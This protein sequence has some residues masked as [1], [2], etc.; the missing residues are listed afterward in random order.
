MWESMATITKQGS[1]WKAQIRRKGLGTATRSFIKKADAEAWARTTEA[2]IERGEFESTPKAKA[3]AKDTTL[4]QLIERYR[5]EISTK[6][7]G[8]RSE[9]YILNAILKYHICNKKVID[10]NSSDWSKYRDVR[11]KEIKETK[12][13]KKKTIKPITLKRQLLIFQHMYEVANNEWG[14]TKLDNP[15]LKVNL[16]Y[17]DT[18]RDRVLKGDEWQRII[19]DAKGRKN[20]LVLQ[21]ILW[22]KETGMRRGE[23][24]SLRW[25]DVDVKGRALVI[26]ETKNG[27]PR[28]LPITKEMLSILEGLDPTEDRV[29]PIREANFDSTWKRIMANLGLSG[30][31]RFH[32]LRHSAVKRLPRM[33]PHRLPNV[34]PHVEAS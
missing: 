24:L 20:P 6:K 17:K 25:S 28:T 16:D 33:T 19:A 11:L 34:T 3:E 13:G 4:G 23:I 29:F 32:D 5:D 30:S 2:L 8:S 1:K 31:L 21:V 9:T 7:K 10:V 14:Y 18:Q 12:G 26:P 15:L 22:A 27:H